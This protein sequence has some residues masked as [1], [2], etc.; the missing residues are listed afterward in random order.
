MKAL[1]KGIVALIK[2]AMTGEAS[3][4]PEGFELSAA[5]P[6]IK[7]HHIVTMAYE[8]AVKC[9]IPQSDPTVKTLFSAYY[10]LLTASERQAAMLGKLVSAFDENEIDYML[11][12]GSNLRSL[13]PRPELRYMGDADVLIKTDQYDRIKPIMLSLGFA[14]G[15]ESDHELVWRGGGLMVELHKRLIP[16][17]NKDFYAYF[18]EGWQNARL[19]AGTRYTM[20]AEDEMIY[21][22]THF[23]KHYRDGGVGCRYVADLY[24]YREAHPELDG[25]YIASVLGRIYLD[26]F[27][28]NVMR[29]VD[30]WFCGGDEDEATEIITEFIFASGSWGSVDSKLIAREVKELKHSPK[31][32]S[33]KM[34]YIVRMLFPSVAALSPKYTVLK[35]APW[36]LPAVWVIRPFYKLFFE[37]GAFKR[38][39]R[40][41]KVI[42]DKSVAER[43]EALNAVGIDFNF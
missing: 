22:F 36:L 27:Y 26:R 20:S 31:M 13:Y 12:K 18:G 24:L 15:V 7:K 41:L 8:G 35:K 2:S 11:L 10:T 21:L 16:S 37:R 17:Y 23:A 5:L 42:N 9:G 25:E 1:H 30:A 28:E 6:L 38:Q 4:L 3:A 34:S 19:D 40:N 39:K 33:S 32:M 14:E 29:T 43:K